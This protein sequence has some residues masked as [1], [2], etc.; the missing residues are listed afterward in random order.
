MKRA[1][2][3][4]LVLAALV[5]PIALLCLFADQE[6]VSFAQ[7]NAVSHAGSITMKQIQYVQENEPF[8]YEGFDNPNDYNWEGDWDAR[9]DRD[10]NGRYEDDRDTDKSPGATAPSK[11]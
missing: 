10:R 8:V 9:A 1:M 5:Y 7:R 2:L 3:H 11:D 4:V 6:N